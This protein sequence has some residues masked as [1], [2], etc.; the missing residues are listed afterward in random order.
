MFTAVLGKTLNCPAWIFEAH[1]SLSWRSGGPAS[2]GLQG[3]S[4]IQANNKEG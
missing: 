1:C 4:N 3:A 2:A